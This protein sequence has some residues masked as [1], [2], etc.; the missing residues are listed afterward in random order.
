MYFCGSLRPKIDETRSGLSHLFFAELMVRGFHFGHSTEIIRRDRYMEVGGFDFTQKRRHDMDLWLRV[1]CGRTWA[2]DAR[3]QAQY[4]I[5]TPGSISKSIINAEYYFLRAL[6]KNRDGFAGEA[7]DSLI[8][9]AARRSVSLA[10]AD[11]TEED[12]RAARELAGPFLS[13]KL[14]AAYRI[15]D[16][17]PGLVRA[18][19]RI[20]RRVYWTL[21]RRLKGID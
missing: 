10:F 21:K 11:G 6:T 7:M 5:D 2:W 19:I 9:T 17:A 8:A 16:F 15:A 20:K 14:Q 12:Y 4:R 13:R 18:A 3:P 1:I